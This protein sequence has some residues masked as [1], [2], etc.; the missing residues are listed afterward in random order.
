MEKTKIILKAF[1]E[2]A[3]NELNSLT[4]IFGERRCRPKEA[5]F[6]GQVND[7]EN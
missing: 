6:L 2:S 4:D 5:I 3:H 7:D 1:L